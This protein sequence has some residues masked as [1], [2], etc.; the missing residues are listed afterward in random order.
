MMNVEPKSPIFA[1][2]VLVLLIA[3]FLFLP[4]NKLQAK[5][6]LWSFLPLEGT[7]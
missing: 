1:C 2:D 3:S 7:N 6:L 4:M 5:P